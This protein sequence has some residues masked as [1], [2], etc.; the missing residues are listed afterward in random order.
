[1]RLPAYGTHIFLHGFHAA[2][3][4][5]RRAMS[6]FARHS[7]AHFFSD[8]FVQ[9]IAQVFIQ[10]LLKLALAEDPADPCREIFPGCHL[11]SP[12]TNRNSSPTI[13][14]TPNSFVG[15]QYAAPQLAQAPKKRMLFRAPIKSASFLAERGNC[16][17]SLTSLQKPR[18]TKPPAKSLRWP[19]PAVPTLSSRFSVFA[20]QLLLANS[21]SHADC[22][23]RSA[24]RTQ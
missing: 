5:P 19:P 23:P 12:T 22:F 2:H 21:I 6:F 24:I 7:R 3:F 18:L 8:G 10:F 16:F 1:M 11:C 4:H 15:A 20:V 9:K 14:A 13:R 17:F